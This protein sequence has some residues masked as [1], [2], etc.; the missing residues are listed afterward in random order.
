M[1]LGDLLTPLIDS[2]HSPLD[3][4]LLITTHELLTETSSP[5][6]VFNL[7]ACAFNDVIL[8]TFSLTI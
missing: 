1:R 4:I 2:Y 7:N 6:I 3:F 5:F 8:F